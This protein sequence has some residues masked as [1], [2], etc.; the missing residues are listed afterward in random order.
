MI[1]DP[2]IVKILIST[3]FKY[4]D[5]ETTLSKGELESFV[6]NAIVKFDDIIFQTL[7]AIFRHSKLV[8]SVDESEDSILS[9]TTNIRLA[10]KHEVK[11]NFERR[12]QSEVL[13]MHCI[14]TFTGHNA[15]SG[16]IT[17]VQQDFMSRVTQLTFNTSMT[18]VM[19]IIRRYTLVSGVRS[20]LDFEA[21]TIN[22]GTGEISIDV[23]SRS[24]LQ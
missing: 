20:V 18:M 19:V 22:Y 2:S 15:D 8:R 17:N 7:I 4:N 12:F 6:R 5:G 16:G 11:V 10:K 21:G 1:V 23:P 13:V 24:L 9:N 3:V 14:I